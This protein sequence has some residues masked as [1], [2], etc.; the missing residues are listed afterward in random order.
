MIKTFALTAL[1]VATL[2]A[3]TLSQISPA[4]AEYNHG[5][6][7]HPCIYPHSKAVHLCTIQDYQ[8]LQK[9]AAAAQADI[10]RLQ[11]QQEMAAEGRAYRKMQDER[12]RNAPTTEHCFLKNGML[13]CKPV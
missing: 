5:G 6:K 2:A 7:I 9:Q 1:T 11:Q 10:K 4:S 12:K 3:A 13:V 8:K